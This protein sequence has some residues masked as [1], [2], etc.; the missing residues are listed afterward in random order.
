MP[1]NHS[2]LQ[3]DL[4]F[5]NNWRQDWAMEFNP[6]KCKVLYISKKK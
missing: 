1:D 5:L 6:T 4:Y 3:N 2:L